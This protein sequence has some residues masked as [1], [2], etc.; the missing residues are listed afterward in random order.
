[1]RSSWRAHTVKVQ[2]IVQIT[3]RCQGDERMETQHGMRSGNQKGT[4][5]SII[6]MPRDATSVATM[7]GLLPPLNSFKTQSRSVCCLSPWI[8]TK[9]S[10]GCQ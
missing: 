9:V 1:M 4:G 5:K 6:P 7:M 3:H 2:S 8:A 10:K